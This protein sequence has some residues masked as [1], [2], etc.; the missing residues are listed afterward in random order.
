MGGGFFPRELPPVFTSESFGNHVSAILSD[1]EQKKVFSTSPVEMRKRNGRKRNRRGAYIYKVPDA[2]IE[3]LTKPKR[4]YER[5]NIHI[6]HPIPQ[7]LLTQELAQNWRTISRW[8][9]R[10][11]FSVDE[12]RWS[13]QDSRGIREINFRVHQAKKLFI[14]S[15]WDWLVQTDI[16]RFYPSIYTHSIPW[17]AYGKERVKSN[18]SQYKGSLADRLDAL[19]RACNRNQTVGIP[20]GPETSR[21][22]AEVVSARIDYEFSEKLSDVHNDR[23]DRLQDDWFI[24]ANSLPEAENILSTIIHLYRHYGLE[25]NGVKTSIDRLLH[26]PANSWILQLS[27]FLSHNA[28]SLSGTRLREFLALSLNVQQEFPTEPVI[29][30]AMSVI[31]GNSYTDD[32]AEAL[33][34]FLIKASVVSPISMDKICR[35][36]INLNYDKRRISKRR[37][38]IR[39][40][41]LAEQSLENGNTYEALWFLYTLRGL[42]FPLNSKPISELMEFHSGSA[43]PLVLLDMKRKGL[44]VQK[45][46]ISKW[47]NMIDEYR[48]EHD[49]VWLLA[50]EG[51]RHGWLK[52]IKGTMTKRFFAPMKTRNVIFYDDTKNVTKSVKAKKD[53]IQRARRESVAV[54]VLIRNMRGILD[55]GDY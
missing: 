7:A 19:V 23:V 35:V 41:K 37:I 26:A 47:E 20:I 40:S 8:L 36:L 5:R 31:E 25:I 17:A 14:G 16:T 53:R 10:A 39:F 54:S 3:V 1:W 52:D 51:I 55:F 32:D 45:L 50:Y 15:S 13:K 2:E 27:G 44:N 12:L 11:E 18:L 49:W 46:P 24:G 30:Y 42:K 33:E 28:K 29:N 9:S 38:G 48:V 21:I 43:I 22:I 34:S 4:G 6:T